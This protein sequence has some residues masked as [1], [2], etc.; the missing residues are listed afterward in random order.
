MAVRLVAYVTSWCP[1][2][3][4]TRRA[5]EEWGVA[6]HYINIRQEP[7]TAERVRAWTGFESVPTL[8][9]AADGSTEPAEPPAPLPRGRGPRGIDRGSMLTEPTREELRMWLVKH[10]LLEDRRG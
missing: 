8:V 3:S 10:G 9:I 6:C 7:G 2:C 5:L 1:N 4:D